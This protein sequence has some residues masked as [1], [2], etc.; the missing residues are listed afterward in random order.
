M[1]MMANPV[2]TAGDVSRRGTEPSRR[3]LVG[4]CLI[5]LGA[6]TL[7]A[8]LVTRWL[9]ALTEPGALSEA[10]TTFHL[11]CDVGYQVFG[12]ASL[13]ILAS[14]LMAFWWIMLRRET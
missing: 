12:V 14:A 10:A 3:S 1:G 5:A 4:T 9:A 13:L 11:C 8:A 7:I 2:R 6:G